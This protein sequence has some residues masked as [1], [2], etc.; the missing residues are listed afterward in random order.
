MEDTFILQ[1]TDPDLL[2]L[3]DVLALTSQNEGDIFFIL[4]DLVNPVSTKIGILKSTTIDESDKQFKIATFNFVTTSEE[5]FF[6]RSVFRGDLDFFSPPTRLGGELFE[7]YK[8]FKINKHSVSSDKLLESLKQITKNDKIILNNEMKIENTP[9]EKIREEFAVIKKADDSKSKENLLR[10]KLEKEKQEA[11]KKA[12][13]ERKDKAL[14]R[15]AKEQTITSN[16]LGEK[17][18]NIAPNI[19][20]NIA[21]K[22]TQNALSTSS[23]FK[24]KYMKYKLKYIELLGKIN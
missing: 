3:E 1:K 20:S 10:D 2:L 9:L 21:P 7:K 4:N 22:I 17:P 11:Q 16:V 14:A 19:T 23:S 24:H 5:T 6:L 18:P 13:Q 15:K 8:I 12:L